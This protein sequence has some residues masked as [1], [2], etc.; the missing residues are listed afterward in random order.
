[1]KYFI[2]CLF[3]TINVFAKTENL[4]GSFKVL[5]NKESQLGPY[6][7]FFVFKYQ[8][9]YMALPVEFKD[10]NQFLKIKQ[11]LQDT[12]V[13]EARFKNENLSLDGNEREIKV[14]AIEK[15]KRVSLK[16]FSMDVVENTPDNS[17]GSKYNPKGIKI[18]KNVR[19]MDPQSGGG[20][21]ISGIN[22]T[23]TNTIIGAGAAALIYSVI[24]G[25]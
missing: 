22:N 16:D 15:F 9:R 19:V 10:K 2:F 7:E 23:L 24:T 3:L 21:T 5:E 4:V 1:M 6:K 25:K 14:L 11:N 20:V 17:E 8:G 13:I 18:G 12:F